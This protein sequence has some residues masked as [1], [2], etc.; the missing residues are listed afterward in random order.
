MAD[1]VLPPRLYNREGNLI[2]VRRWK[3]TPGDNLPIVAYRPWWQPDGWRPHVGQIPIWE[4]RQHRHLF[5]IAGSQGGK[6]NIGP[7]WL[8]REIEEAVRKYPGQELS[9][10]IVAPSYRMT[11]TTNVGITRMLQ[12]F[13]QC[14]GW[15]TDDIFSRKWL[16]IDLQSVGWPVHI[17]AG[18]GERPRA[19]QGGRLEAVW[20]DEAGMIPYEDAF[21]ETEQRLHGVGRMLITT[22]PYVQGE[23]LKDFMKKAK[24]NDPDTMV[25]RYPS[26]VSPYF[27]I[28]EWDNA[29]RSNPPLFFRERWGARFELPQG[30]VYPTTEYVEPFEIPRDWPRIMGI[31][32]NHGGSDP[33]AVAWI[34]ID[35]ITGVWYIYREYYRPSRPPPD[36]ID[37]SYK[38][39]SD[40]M[41]EVWEMSVREIRN[42]ETGRL[43]QT[44][45]REHIS[46]IF[47]DPQK[48][49]LGP[50]LELMF[51]DSLVFKADNRLSGIVDV[52]RALHLGNLC[53]FNDLLNWRFEQTHYAYPTDQYGRTRANKPTDKFNHL[54]DG[55]R[56]A[57][58]QPAEAR[59]LGEYHSA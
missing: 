11:L 4:D 29:K 1:L 32:P 10:G 45:E 48:A 9:F 54:M 49:E 23:W 27:S 24:A 34:A 50:T 44:D 43:E 39:P 55:T 26:I 19:L 59:D 12:F 5:M 6:S 3:R 58:H 37:T 33:Y 35:P 36:A 56:Y 57:V 52:Q 38:S 51:P 40:I 14:F 13:R 42:E 15:E 25:V 31:D 22:T 18:S 2:T 8:W 46:R 53:V 7:P 41:D 16:Q 17:Y 28:E 47:Y 30:L 21:F 20:M